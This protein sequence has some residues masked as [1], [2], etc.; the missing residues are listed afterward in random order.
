[1]QMN[2]PVLQF[3]QY[4]YY[5][6]LDIRLNINRKT[7]QKVLIISA[8]NLVARETLAQMK[9]PHLSINAGRVTALLYCYG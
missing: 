9:T 8:V 1:M 7:N 2:V 6:R 4:N 3:A 5:D